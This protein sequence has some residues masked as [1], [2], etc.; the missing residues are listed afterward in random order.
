MVSAGRD[1]EWRCSGCDRGWV[2]FVPG[3]I[4]T[5]A[6]C[7]AHRAELHERWVAGALMPEVP[8]YWKTAA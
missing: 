7:A 8:A 3:R 4:P 1:T 6:P 2:V 5:V